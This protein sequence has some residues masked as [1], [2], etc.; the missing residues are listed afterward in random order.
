MVVQSLTDGTVAAPANPRLTVEVNPVNTM[1][2]SIVRFFGL[3]LAIGIAAIGGLWTLIA[4]ALAM[5]RR[6]GE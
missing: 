6:I 2:E 1:G 3:W 4:C 5:R